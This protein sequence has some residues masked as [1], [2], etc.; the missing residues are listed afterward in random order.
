VDPC[1]VR[2]LPSIRWPFATKWAACQEHAST[3]PKSAIHSVL[4]GRT[5]NAAFAGDHAWPRP[6]HIGGPT[7]TWNTGSTRPMAHSGDPTILGVTSSSTMAAGTGTA[8][9]GFGSRVTNGPPTWVG[10]WKADGYCG[11]APLPP[12][13]AFRAGVGPLVQPP[14]GGRCRFRFR[15]RTLPLQFHQGNYGCFRRCSQFLALRGG[16]DAPIRRLWTRMIGD[17]RRAEYLR[18]ETC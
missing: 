7:V 4:R 15:R 1:A 18:K 6:T 16:L 3:V 13:A 5:T 12:G 8:S 10:W 14:P 2:S 9:A 17:S 11:W